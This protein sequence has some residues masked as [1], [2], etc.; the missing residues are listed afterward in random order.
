MK[1]CLKSFFLFFWIPAFAGL[2]GFAGMTSFAISGGAEPVGSCQRAFSTN[3]IRSFF[4]QVENINRYAGQQGYLLFTEQASFYRMST[5]Y[6]KVSESLGQRFKLLYWQQFHGSTKEFKELRGYVLNERG[7]FKEEYR[8][9]EGYARL[10]DEHFAGDMQKTFLNVSAVLDKAIFK[11]AGWQQFHGST[12]EFKELRGYVLNE[13]GEFKEEYRAME[14]YARLADAYFAGDMLK[15]FKNVSAVLDKA[16]FKS[17]GWQQ[18]H[19]ST[20][21]F[22]EL[23]GYVLNE[24]GEFKEEYRAME[25]YARL[26]DA[27]FAGDML[28]TF[29]NVSAVLDKA[30]FKSAGWQQFHGSTKEFKELRGYVLNERGE[31]KEEYRA[32]EGYARLADAYFAG[33]MLKT[34][35]NVS[36]VLDK[37]IFKS[38]GWQQFHGSTKEF[39][40]LRGYVLNERGEF[41]E[42]YRAME[43]YARLADAYFAGGMQKTFIN[44]SAVLDKAIFESAGWQLFQGSTKEFKELRGYVLN[45]RGEFKEEYR[46]MEGYARLADEHFAGGMQKTFINV[47]A[48]LDKAIL[49]SAGWQL[50][51]GSTKEF[52]ELR[53]YVLNERGEFKEEYRAMEG[54]AR[55]ADEHFAGGMQKT[56]INVSAVFGGYRHIKELEWKSF[57]G[58]T[59]EYRQLTL[60]FKNT[61]LED[62]QGRDGQKKV[63]QLIFNNQLQRTYINVSTLRK[64][65]FADPAHFNALK[66]FK[67]S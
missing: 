13:R 58:T 14:G 19:G 64:I 10:A 63:A 29:L 26:A 46:A 41:K 53:G 42:E 56:F 33:D 36:A 6:R 57:N 31:F 60:F 43:G 5:V 35:L 67:P 23:R 8:A 49:K 21:E 24:R 12:K 7:E 20:K 15:T 62:I 32:M 39:K 59:N 38:A 45:E 18:F 4:S 3:G 17:A 54:Y 28:K 52:K 50:F 40:E 61:Q 1:L 25:G 16:I 9:M 22:K 51:Q 34:F 48:V 27:Y 11:S 47:S 55:L 44:V 66:W 2:T 65:L 37:A 30:I